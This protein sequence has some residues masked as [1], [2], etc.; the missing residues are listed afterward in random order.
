MSV[1]D[2]SIEADLALVEAE[3]HG[4][5]TRFRVLG[6]LLD[7]ERSRQPLTPLG[8][9]KAQPAEL[10]QEANARRDRLVV[11]RRDPGIPGSA[12]L[13]R[14][15]QPLRRK[16]VRT[17]GDIHDCH[18]VVPPICS[19]EHP[20]KAETFEIFLD[21]LAAAEPPPFPHFRQS[22]I[23]IQFAIAA[24]QLPR[25]IEMSRQCICRYRHAQRTQRVG[26]LV[27]RHRHPGQSLFVPATQE[28]G[29]R[30]PGL[31]DPKRRV[32]RAEAQRLL[33]ILDG[34][35]RV[36]KVGPRIAAPHPGIRIVRVS[37]HRLVETGD[38]FIEPANIVNQRLRIEG[39]YLRVARI[40]L[41]CLLSRPLG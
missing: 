25:H 9:A 27:Q 39:Q 24:Q 35:L 28:M 20:S 26:A 31:R 36:A 30:H 17:F 32:E 3:H 16:I 21:I 10:A 7:N 37:A 14:S 23:G 12:A 22:C 40:Q 13:Q 29:V 41:H 2:V 19:F 11:E 6:W 4:E 1:R 15:G 5:L 8:M 38:R 18:G 33:K 34:S